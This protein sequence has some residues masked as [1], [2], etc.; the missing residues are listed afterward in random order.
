[1]EPA[2]ITL[3]SGETQANEIEWE[4]GGGN[5]ANFAIYFPGHGL[6]DIRPTRENPVAVSC[7]TPYRRYLRLRGLCKESYLDTLYT[8]MHVPDSHSVNY[9][10]N[11]MDRASGLERT[12][13]VFVG[14]QA[15]KIYYDLKKE[16]WT[17]IGTWAGYGHPDDTW[18]TSVVKD[19]SYSQL[20]T[21]CL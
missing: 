16:A 18:G 9:P 12:G 17:I 19:G 8:P 7:L 13:L 10:W 20:E 3:I 1:V 14:T 2:L 4:F 21:D 15:T 11:G 5:G 6:W